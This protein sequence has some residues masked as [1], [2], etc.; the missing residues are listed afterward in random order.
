[1]ATTSTARECYPFAICE[2]NQRSAGTLDTRVFLNVGE[3]RATSSVVRS[4]PAASTAIRSL[5]PGQR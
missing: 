1:M 2:A 4:M 5:A 3:R